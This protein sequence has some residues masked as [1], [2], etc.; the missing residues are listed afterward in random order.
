[1]YFLTGIFLHVTLF[2]CT[3]FFAF[4]IFRTTGDGNCLYSACSIALCGN[5]SLASY[6]C[7][8]T[9]IELFLNSTFYAKHLILLSSSTTKAPFSSIANT[10]ANT[11]AKCLSDIALNSVTKEDHSKPIIA[12]AYSNTMNHQWSSFVCLL[13]LSSEVKVPIE[14]YFPVTRT[15]S[16]SKEKIESLSTLFNGTIYA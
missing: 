5:E 11:F 6:L 13:T 7:C 8:L 10:I 3:W 12:E 2:T 9:S 14:S 15:E 1:M 4:P 16:I